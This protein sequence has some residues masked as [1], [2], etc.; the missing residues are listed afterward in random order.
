MFD[1]TQLIRIMTNLLKNAFQAIPDYREP[2][3]KVVIDDD[4]DNVKN[5][6]F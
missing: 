3:I 4:K 2:E 1:R 6:Y 5:I